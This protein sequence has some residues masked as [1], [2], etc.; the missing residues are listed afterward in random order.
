M[1]AARRER[2]AAL[3]SIPWGAKTHTCSGAAA[4]SGAACALGHFCR[5][6]NL[7][8]GRRRGQRPVRVRARSVCR[9][10][11][12][13]CCRPPHPAAP[14][15]LQLVLMRWHRPRSRRARLLTP[16][17][18]A[19]GFA[20][21]RARARTNHPDAATAARA[22]SPARA[23]RG[24]PPPCLPAAPRY[25]ASPIVASASPA[26]LPF[27]PPGADSLMGSP[28]MRC[29]GPLNE[30]PR[31][32]SCKRRGQRAATRT[33]GAA[34]RAPRETARQAAAGGVE[35]HAYRSGRS[36]TLM[37]APPNRVPLFGCIRAGAACVDGPPAAA[38]SAASRP[39]PCA[40]PR[41]AACQGDAVRAHAGLRGACAGCSPL[42]GLPARVIHPATVQASLR[43]RA[44]RFLASARAAP[45]RA[46][47]VP[48]PACGPLAPHLRIITG[49]CSFT[50]P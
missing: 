2:G 29:T 19:A 17:L 28:G 21:T 35:R 44:L 42:E 43:P 13:P 30:L 8:H 3:P 47:A 39:P 23:R 9:A 18:P 1:S 24:A 37:G 16:R 25:T 14:P 12:A 20:L 41:P 6:N 10:A 15:H 11:S 46:R 26:H 38:Q 45:R 48:W 32:A 40:S 31:P 50:Q 49:A 4:V 7:L 33:G 22:R 5:S 27:A 34:A 36:A